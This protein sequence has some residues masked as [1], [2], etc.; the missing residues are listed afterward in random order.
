M[1]LSS[2][3]S[4]ICSIIV[5]E[6]RMVPFSGS[7][8]LLPEA[9]VPTAYTTA[10]RERGRKPDRRGRDALVVSGPSMRSLSVR[11]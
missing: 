7:N 11:R 2:R 3:A 10:M 8:V 5:S 9:I 6:P 1:L 4:R